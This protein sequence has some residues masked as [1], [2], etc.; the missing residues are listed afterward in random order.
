MHAG[1]PLL[2]VTLA[3]AAWMVVALLVMFSGLSIVVLSLVWL[4]RK[5]LGR[6]QLRLPH[7]IAR[8]AAYAQRPH[9]A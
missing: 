9:T 4:E 6:L 5:A 3:E 8:A 2:A 1:I 7:R